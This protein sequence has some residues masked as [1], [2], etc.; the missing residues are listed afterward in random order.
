MKL[1][2]SKNF[3][4]CLVG[5]NVT[6]SMISAFAGSM[7]GVIIGALSLVSCYIVLYTIE[8]EEEQ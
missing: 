3:W 6:S 7:E 8:K 5:V 2:K 1:L 4:L